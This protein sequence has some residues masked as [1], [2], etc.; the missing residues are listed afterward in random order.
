M[1]ETLSILRRIARCLLG[2]GPAVAS[3][4][5][6]VPRRTIILATTLCLLAAFP[7]VAD[8]AD[9][10][11]VRQDGHEIAAGDIPGWKLVYFGYTQCPDVCPTSL[12]SM[13]LALNAL[14]PVGE[15]ITPV[16]V[17]VDP[18][19]DT[20]KVV[21]EY[22]SYFHPRMIGISPHPDQLPAL[23]AAWHVKYAR[24]ELKDKNSYS[25]DH[26]AMIFLAD[27]S[28]AIVGRYPHDLDGDALADRIRATMLAR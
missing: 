10:V 3:A 14:G 18:E 25:I 22:V 17:T 2:I 16:F 9:L 15:R 11:G 6:G 8:A 12:Q 23:A 5:A 20:P 24:V 7:P 19:R 4:P 26:T 21:A 28:G 1:F 27:P 13:T